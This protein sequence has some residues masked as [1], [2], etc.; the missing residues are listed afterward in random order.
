MKI[1]ILTEYYPDAERP[2]RG[3]YVH[4]RAAGYRSAGHDVR[5]YRVRPGPTRSDER[6]GVAVLSSG[7]IAAAADLGRFRPDVLAL[8]TP[9]PGA[10]HT[11]LARTVQ[12]PRVVWIHGYEA[13][14]T[15]LHGYHRGVRRALSLAGDAV[16]L[17]R[18]RRSLPD[19]AA[20]VFVSE[21]L[22]ASVERTL[23]LR[24][25]GARVIP[26][27]VDTERFRP[28]AAGVPGAVG[29]SGAPARGSHRDAATGGSGHDTAAGR[30]GDGPAAVPRGLV[31]RPLDR[32]HGVDV[33]VEGF[34]GLSTTE[35]TVVGTG[36]D[37]A[38]LRN[39][40]E[41]TGA[42]VRIEEREV[43]HAEVPDLLRDH[44]YYVSPE[45]K[46]P[47]QGVAMCEAMSCGLPV[48][49]VRAGGVPEYARDGTDGHLIPRGRPEPLRDAVRR[50]VADPEAM[51]AMGRRAR[52]RIVQTCSA[53]RVTEAELRVLRE[54]V[55]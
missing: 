32:I 45:R 48:V 24:H 44:D 9:Y 7:P 22:R 12:R 36:P 4:L 53:E 38:E 8:H 26:N 47:T 30:P 1:A 33:A 28:R 37:A 41:A 19:A 25:P 39:R 11:E 17:W 15:A 21:W 6:D 50:L 16:K 54:A 40:I 10:P 31:L 49:A 29:G 42:P 55:E 23:R 51:R 2:G 18:L 5:V 3:V 20:V 52:E 46:T 35:L 13:M 14:V 34:V 43:P 27:P